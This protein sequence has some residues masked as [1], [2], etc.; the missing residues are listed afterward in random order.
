MAEP[1]SDA[2]TQKDQMQRLL[3]ATQHSVTREEMVA[4]FA[5][6]ESV[7][8][9][10]FKQIDRKFDELR[11]EIKGQGRRHARLSWAI[12]TGMLAVFFKGFII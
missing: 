6:S 7:N 1:G 10:R 8:T 12:F 3:N 11:Q 9:E 4:Q 5:Q 2:F